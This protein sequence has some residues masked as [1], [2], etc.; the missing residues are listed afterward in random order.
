MRAPTG[1]VM[2]CMSCFID[3]DG[4]WILACLDTAVLGLTLVLGVL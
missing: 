2:C 4:S 3:V 1:N